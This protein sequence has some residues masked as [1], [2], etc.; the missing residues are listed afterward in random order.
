MSVSWEINILG[1]IKAVQDSLQLSAVRAD[2]INM[3][4]KVT[5]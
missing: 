4:F 2:S 1:K 5:K 3:Y